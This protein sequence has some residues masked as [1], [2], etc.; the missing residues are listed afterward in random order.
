MLGPPGSG[1]GTQGARLAER[2]G[3]AHVSSGELLRAHVLDGTEL[4]RAAG[5]AMSRGELI[6]D[7][8][9]SSMVLDAVI[10]P[11]STGGFV[12]DGFP[13]TVPQAVAAYDI[14]RRHGVTLHAVVLLEIPYD[15]LLDRLIERGRALGRVDDTRET[16]RRRIDVYVEHTLPLVEY[17][18]ERDIIVRVDATGTVDDVTASINE[19][20]DDVVRN[21]DSSPSR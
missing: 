3:V 1:K 6:A 9:V 12:L 7:E 10:G 13:R 19:A 20:L 4:G 16:I 18:R 15:L 17:Y 21:L 5:E 11:G 8:L 14:A 2:H